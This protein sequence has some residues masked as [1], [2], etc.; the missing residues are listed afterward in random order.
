MKAGVRIVS[1]L[2]SPHSGSLDK[3]RLSNS[4]FVHEARPIWKK[5]SINT[6][7]VI[8]SPAMKML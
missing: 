7:T 4:L 2:V 8:T 6:V 1:M 3:L 5:R